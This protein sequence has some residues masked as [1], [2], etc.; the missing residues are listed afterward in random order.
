MLAQVLQSLKSTVR[1]G[2]TPQEMAQQAKDELQK[3]GGTPAFLGFENYP[4]VICISVNNEVQHAIPSKRPFENGDIV[5]FDFGVRHKGMITD[6]G[7]SVCVGNR[8]S[9]DQK[10]LLQGT[11]EALYAAIDIIKPGVRV[12]DISAAIERVLRSYG[13]GIV[14][15][16]VG[17]GV[18]HELHEEPN[19]PNY[20]KAGTGVELRAGMTIAI[21]PITTLGGSDIFTAHDGWTLLTSDGSISAQ[22]EHTVLVTESGSEILTKL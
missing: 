7:L 16:L 4:D 18:G 15:D 14:K 19:I 9:K 22:F 1:A 13:L 20:G 2:M 12:G 3:L 11:E 5:N 8:P 21:E 17:H 10:R 6:G